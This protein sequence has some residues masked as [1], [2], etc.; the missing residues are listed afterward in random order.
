MSATPSP[1]VSVNGVTPSAL[2]NSTMLPVG[3][4]FLFTLMLNASVTLPVLWITIG[5]PP[6]AV[7]PKVTGV[8]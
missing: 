5:S 6:P 8:P 1:F 4:V 7:T 2:N 3:K